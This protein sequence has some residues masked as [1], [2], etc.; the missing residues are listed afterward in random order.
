MVFSTLSFYV[1]L[2]L[3]GT[4]CRMAAI[5]DGPGIIINAANPP[6][7]PSEFIQ[8]QLLDQ[9]LVSYVIRKRAAECIQHAEG[10]KGTSKGPLF[11]ATPQSQLYV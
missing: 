2:L 8:A 5:T 4:A 9:L 10:L 1:F 7:L 3:I 6:P 11:T